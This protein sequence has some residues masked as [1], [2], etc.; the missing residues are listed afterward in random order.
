MNSTATFS[1]ALPDKIND[2]LEKIKEQH[3]SKY[4]K[5]L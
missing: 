4:K 1:S 3:P 2:N 5:E